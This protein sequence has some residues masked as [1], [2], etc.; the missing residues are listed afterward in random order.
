MFC[1]IRPPAV[2][3]FR[4][5]T[6]SITLPL[7]LAYIAAALEE[8]GHRV[9]VV[10]AVAEAPLTK[11][12]Y[13]GRAYLV[14]LSLE[15][16]VA[17]IP[18]PA[19]AVGITAIF[20]H[21]W[22]AVV[23]I[24]ELIKR[25]R[26]GLTVVVGGEHVTSMPEF[27]LATSKAD[28]L[29]LGE[30]EETVV[31]FAEA[32]EKGRPLAEVDGLAYREA[33][34]I[35][36]NRRRRRRHDVDAIAP[37][38]WHLFDVTTYNRHGYVEGLSVDAP[39]M[40][41]IATRGCPYQ[42]TY[43]SA[44]NMWTPRWIP[45]DPLKVVDEIEGYMETYG[46]RNFL[47]Q[48]LTAIIS[49]EWIVAFCNELLKR[50]LDISWQLPSGTRSEA[51]DF[52]VADLLKRSGMLTTSY[53][54][55]SGSERTRTLIKKKMKTESLMDSI[56]AAMKVELYV[57]LYIV[58][59]FPHDSE[60]ELA[61][62]LPFLRRC[63]EMGVPDMVI[64]YFMALP[65]TQLFHSLYDAGKLCLDAAYFNHIQQGLALWPAISHNDALNRWQLTKWKFRLYLAFYGSKR[66]NGT[67]VGLAA[68]A[69]KAL[70][71]LFSPEHDSRLQTAFLNGLA[72]ARD[73]FMVRFA[74]RWMPLAEE[75][76]M[77]AGWDAVYRDIRRQ[78]IDQGIFETAPA[79]TTEIHRTNVIGL[80]R[81]DHQTARAL[82]DPAAAAT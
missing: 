65:G 64:G 58:I 50:K 68:T 76:A 13:H 54:P 73:S 33:G 57:M 78:V 60:E 20:T 56:A 17:R 6:A 15:D 49:K 4:F 26:P 16:I 51:I 39:T 63:A 31:A 14:G 18:G 48:D 55:E 1:L 8:A 7:G 61:E 21:E 42:C 34:L 66:R 67:R 28:A 9:G 70:R 81:R 24:I 27:S 75:R 23:R 32:M 71:G 10:D 52:E 25:A 79:D 69:W 77:F 41:L 47:F 11:R 29:V 40:T 46:A 22:P 44:P 72:S 45:R 62:N 74:P 82:R 2:E 37:P 30:G 80:L 43:C 38:A 59:G 53:A 35:K 3:S 5:S 19:T 12:R 36:V